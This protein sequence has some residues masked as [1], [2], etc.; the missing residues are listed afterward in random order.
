MTCVGS[1]VTGQVFPSPAVVGK[2][3]GNALD[4]REAMASSLNAGRARADLDTAGPEAG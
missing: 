1:P 3:A 4:P 2:V